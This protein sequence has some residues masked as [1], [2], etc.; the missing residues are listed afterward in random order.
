MAHDGRTWLPEALDALA[1]QTYTA[2]EVVAVDNASGDGSRE[3]L[4]ERLGEHR[5]LVA[6]RDLGFAGAV[7]M[8]LDARAADAAPYVLLLHDDLQLA[9]DAVA[10]LV[11]ALERDPRLA[12]VGPK[13]CSWD[14]PERLQA[15]G[16]TIDLTGRVD[17]GVEIDELDQ[18]QRDQQRRALYVSTAGM[19]VRRGALDGLGRLDRRYHVFRDDLD[20]CWR[21]WLAGHDVEVVPQATATH[22][23]GAANYLRLGQTR[24]L[25]PRYFDERN[26]LATL[27]KNYGPLRLALVLPLFLLVGVAKTLGFLLTRRFSD[28]WQTV[29]AWLWNL[30][31]L[32]ETRRY[33]RDV[34]QQRVRTD[35]ELAE[36]FGRL[37]PRIRA[38]IEAMASWVAGGDTALVDEAPASDV[39]APEPATA[40]ARARAL[41]RRRPVLI[42]GALLLVLALVGTWPLL[43]PG[44]LRGGQ[45][46]S[47]P[48]SPAAFLSDHVAGWSTAGAFGTSLDPSPAQAVLGLLHLAVGGSSYLAPRVLLLLP[49]VLAWV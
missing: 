48:A 38:Y 43:R 41:I 14:A 35:A 26:A 32:R 19:L 10:T 39:P 11:D 49:F 12:I 20:L 1:A 16:S 15:V 22:A 29:R 3:L 37:T 36:L 25:G 6:D 13:L 9:P 47:W 18:G 33:R 45:L 34:Q 31:H 46:A 17:T 23:A 5:V 27:L 28:A 8:A 21:A 44:A 42:S 30:V 2:I 7:S 4:L 40:T 24:F